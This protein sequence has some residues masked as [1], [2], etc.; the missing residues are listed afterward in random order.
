VALLIRP[1]TPSSGPLFLIDGLPGG[2]KETLVL[3]SGDITT[4]L[5]N[6]ATFTK[7]AGR[8]KRVHHSKR[9]PLPITGERFFFGLNICLIMV[10]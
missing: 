5:G 8:E 6:T 3:S 7:G 4:I 1:G 10:N 2:G 9:L